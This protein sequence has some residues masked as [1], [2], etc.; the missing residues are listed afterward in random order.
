MIPIQTSAE[1][2]I[3]IVIPLFVDIEGGLQPYVDPLS[4][5]TKDVIDPKSPMESIDVFINI[6]SGLISR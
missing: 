6:L 2:N 1:E 3:S 4:S 5:E